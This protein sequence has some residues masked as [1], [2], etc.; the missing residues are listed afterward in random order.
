[1]TSSPTEPRKTD[2]DFEAL[3]N[4]RI[5]GAVQ[6]AINRVGRSEFEKI[7][8]IDDQEL[9]LILTSQDQYLP[10]PV[11]TLVCQINRS[12]NDPDPF[13]SSLAE[14][15]K[16]T[17]IRIPPTGEK[18]APPSLVQLRGRRRLVK[19]KTGSTPTG[20]LIDGK[21][22][23]FLGFVANIA[24]FFILGYF[25]GGVGLSPLIGRSGCVG[26]AQSSPW[27]VP[28]EGSY[29]GLVVGAVAG[30]GYTYYYFVK[31]L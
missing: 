8:G 2:P 26:V 30:L 6:A 14:C 20:P 1:M 18:S 29:V 27:L 5:A 31:K 16:G 13:H 15:L 22:M 7:K 10:V 3:V 17:T 24:S 21:G 9:N 28:C 23:R 11:V 25:L 12:H 19:A 4:D